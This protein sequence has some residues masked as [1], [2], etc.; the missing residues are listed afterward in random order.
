MLRSASESNLSIKELHRMCSCGIVQR[1]ILMD[2]LNM[3]N[4]PRLPLFKSLLFFSQSATSF[5][6]FQLTFIFSLL[7]TN[8]VMT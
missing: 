7:R 2:V 1:W 3:S 8:I 6:W 4:C 5:P